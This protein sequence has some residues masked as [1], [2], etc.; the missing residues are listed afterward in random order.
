MKPMPLLD[1]I[2]QWRDDLK[3]WI[4]NN[5]ATKEDLENYLNGNK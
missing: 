1:A 2:R 4:K 5:F 3:L